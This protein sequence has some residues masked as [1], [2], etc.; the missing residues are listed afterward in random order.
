[1]RNKF[2]YVRFVGLLL[3]ASACAGVA[4][5]AHADGV[6]GA[7]RK[8]AEEYLAALAGGSP[9]AIALSVH[10]DELD[11]LRITLMTKLREEAARGASSLRTRLFGTAQSSADL[12][13][14]TSLAFFQA[15]QRRVPLRGRGYEE[16]KGLVSVV[17]GRL[18]QVVVKGMPAKGRGRT[19]V[20]E[21]VALL[22]YGKDWKAALPAAFEAA[23]EDLVDGRDVVLPGV[24][25]VATATAGAGAGATAAGAGT[26]AAAIPAGGAAPASNSAEI[27]AL[28]DSAEKSL[29]DGRCEDYYR[30]DL[31]PALRKSLSGRAFDMLV[32]SC[33]NSVANRETLIAALRIVRRLPP[34]Y[35]Y[36]GSRASYD[37]SGQGL[38]YERFTLERVDNRWYIAE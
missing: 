7:Q 25:A 18:V 27:I 6:S 30:Q 24:T 35:E 1:M 36:D 22:P 31:S 23:V 38:P 14:L 28:L 12:E 2:R 9:Q 32:S 5:P 21:V 11:R 10:P 17:D 33:R 8:A 13:K 19:E 29:V 3:A 20:V 26:A 16:V 4:A 15:L 34:R 37:V